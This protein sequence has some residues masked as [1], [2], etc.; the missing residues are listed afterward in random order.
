MGWIPGW[1]SLW[2]KKI[3]KANPSPHDIIKYHHEGFIFSVTVITN[4]NLVHLTFLIYNGYHQ[5][6]L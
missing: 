5:I 4:V 6:F 2:I 3:V 1:G